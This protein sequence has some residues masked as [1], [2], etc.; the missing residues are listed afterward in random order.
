MKIGM[1]TSI[2]LSVYPSPPDNDDLASIATP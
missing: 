1:R 2:A